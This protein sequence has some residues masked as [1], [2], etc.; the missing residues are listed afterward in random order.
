M[1]NL[2]KLKNILYLIIFIVTLSQFIKFYSFYEEYSAWQYADWLINYQGGFVRRGLIGEI[3]FKIYSFT[4][5]RLDYL[6]LILLYL[7]FSISFLTLIKSVKYIKNSFIDLMIFLSPGFFIYPFMNS[8]VIG[9][10]DV[11]LVSIIGLF[12]FYYEK[13]NRNFQF[14]VFIILIFLLSLSHT[15]F[16]FY[17]QYLIFFYFLFNYSKNRQVKKYQL[18][19][20]FF[21]IF[22]L[23]ILTFI[24]KGTNSEVLEICNSI[25]NFIS[26]NCGKSDQ[27]SWLAKDTSDYLSSKFSNGLGYFLN[28]FFVYFISLIWVYFFLCLKIYNSSFISSF[29]RFNHINPLLI[30][31]IL[32]L[33]TSPVFILGIDWGRYIYLSYSCSFF[34]YI[35][36]LRKRLFIFK[37]K[38]VNFTFNRGLSI[39]IVIIYCFIWTFPFYNAVGFKFTLKKPAIS[40]INKITHGK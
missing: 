15:G 13:I 28:N 39:I 37:K 17:T 24:F 40:L 16:I 22:I 7:L 35:F 4:S 31:T 25:K 19:I 9:R 14:F 20:I 10:K 30:F 21:S 36:C 26:E 33:I 11:L 29:K 34:I 2:L 12:T 6:V 27:I 23:L 3:L 32:F 8:E 18:M 5:I 1:I 38:I